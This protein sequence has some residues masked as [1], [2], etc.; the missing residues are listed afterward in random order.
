M[1]TFFLHKICGYFSSQFFHSN[2]SLIFQVLMGLRCALVASRR[3]LPLHFQHTLF[4]TLCSTLYRYIPC[5]YVLLLSFPCKYHIIHYSLIFQCLLK[6]SSS[7]DVAIEVLIE[8]VSRHEVCS[9]DLLYI[10]VFMYV[11]V[12]LFKQYKLSFCDL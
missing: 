2:L 9:L 8:L 12:R 10:Y 1:A 5:F 4:S 11:Y 7:F 3:F 6:V